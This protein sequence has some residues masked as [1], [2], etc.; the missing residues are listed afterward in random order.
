MGSGIN[1]KINEFLCN[2]KNV[3]KRSTRLEKCYGHV[4]IA[5][6]FR[7]QLHYRS[8]VTTQELFPQTLSAWYQKK[9][10]SEALVLLSY[11]VRKS[12]PHIKQGNPC[13][14]QPFRDCRRCQRHNSNHQVWCSRSIQLTARDNLQ[15]KRKQTREILKLSN[16]KITERCVRLA[17]RLLQTD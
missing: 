9:S 5:T 10:I 16:H 6:A 1:N 4:N 2:S 11:S 14:S 12:L 7:K 3:K 17:L 8:S 15:S 13:H